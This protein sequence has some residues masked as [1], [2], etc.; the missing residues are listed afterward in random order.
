M[1]RNELKYNSFLKLEKY[2]QKL[3][4]VE[5]KIKDTLEK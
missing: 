5:L 2:Q 4:K 1:K 3:Q